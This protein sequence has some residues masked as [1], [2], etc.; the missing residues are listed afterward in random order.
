MKKAPQV[1]L[2][3]ALLAFAACTAKPPAA[4]PPPVVTVT[5]VNYAFNAPDTIAAGVTTFKLLNKGTELHHLQLIKLNDGKTLA[6]LLAAI[7]KPGPFP[8][9][10]TFVGGPNAIIPGDS[11]E[12]TLALAPGH[13]A[14]ICLVP[15]P[16]G[17]PH[18]LKGMHRALEVVPGQN[19][20]TLPAADVTVGLVEYGFQI[21]PALT[22][23]THTIRFVNKGTQPHEAVL[24]RLAPGK[25]AQDVSDWVNGGMKGPPPGQP[26]G[27][28]SG[29]SPGDSTTFTVNL[30][31]GNYGFLCFFPDQKD[32]KPH[33]LHGMIQQFAIQ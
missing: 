13:Y 30:T 20:A 14:M 23:G 28:T 26:I 21:S 16:D 10:A 7:A 11:T 17:V 2:A 8:D 31:P 4:S 32:G 3:A 25:T 9:W 5:A 15:A 19:N 6:D 22:A 1:S 12:T 29:I 24:A 33:D 27:G 18:V